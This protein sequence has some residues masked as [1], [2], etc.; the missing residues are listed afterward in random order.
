MIIKLKSCA[1]EGSL[2]VKNL[3]HEYLRGCIVPQNFEA[4]NWLRKICYARHPQGQALLGLMYEQGKGVKR[5]VQKHYIG[6]QNLLTMEIHWDSVILELCI[7]R[8]WPPAEL[9]RSF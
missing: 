6:F 3:G 5:I 9:H 8:L 4:E 2:N 7:Q 1:E